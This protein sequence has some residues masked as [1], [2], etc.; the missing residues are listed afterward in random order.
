MKKF[1][2]K[3]RPLYEGAFI[4]LTFGW[5]I[6]APFYR[7]LLADSTLSWNHLGIWA[8]AISIFLFIIERNIWDVQT[9]INR[10]YFPE[11]VLWLS[12]LGGSLVSHSWINTLFFCLQ[13]SGAA[14]I[15]WQKCRLIY[16][17]E[18]AVTT[19]TGALMASTLFYY[20]TSF[21]I[22]MQPGMVFAYLAITGLIIL[23]GT[24]RAGV[25]DGS[26]QGV[27]DGSLLKEKE[28]EE[29][30][31][32]R[33]PLLL[34]LIALVS[35]FIVYTQ[36]TFLMNQIFREISLFGSSLV[37]WVIILYVAMLWSLPFLIR[38]YRV[39]FTMGFII[40]LAGCAFALSIPSTRIPM[41][42]EVSL[43]LFVIASAGVDSFLLLM[44]SYL[45]KQFRRVLFCAWGVVSYYFV[46]EFS[47]FIAA[48]YEDVL[49]TYLMEYKLLSLLLS[50]VFVLLLFHLHYSE[51]QEHNQDHLIRE[52]SINRDPLWLKEL[53]PAEKNI[54]D[55]IFEGLTN[56][57]IAEHLFISVSTVKFHVHNILG[58]AGV[59]N[60]YELLALLQREVP[61]TTKRVKKEDN[62]Y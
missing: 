24:A 40:S 60:K 8:G 50:F 42:Q 36:G 7:P 19:W 12:F 5:L 34:V 47:S 55:H 30:D 48:R 52:D 51:M 4:G 29:A 18:D 39:L 2:F 15:L 54:L 46:M 28:I 57:Q 27:G 41:I 3:E 13:F 25:G 43:S 16:H 53:T 10:P 56:Q 6:S 35:M 32:P 44:I 61:L 33:R 31:M 1:R 62:K 21:V 9:K 22:E 58:K 37:I 45:A 49:A 20:L 26:F 17:T 23:L 11:M 38:K 59:K 14:A